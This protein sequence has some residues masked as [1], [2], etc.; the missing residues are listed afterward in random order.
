[1][2]LWSMPVVERLEKCVFAIGE[3]V[4]LYYLLLKDAWWMINNWLSGC[5][6]Y[7]SE[8]GFEPTPTF[9]D[10]KSYIDCL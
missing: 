6:K 8:V 2:S 7:V 1:M 9:V 3:H 5:K 4:W 10:Q